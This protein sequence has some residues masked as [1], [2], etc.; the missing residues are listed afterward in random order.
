MEQCPFLEDVARIITQQ[1]AQ[2]VEEYKQSQVGD[3]FEG[4]EDGAAKVSGELAT[5][6]QQELFAAC[7]WQ[8]GTI[9]QVADEIRRLRAVEEA[10]AWRPIET[11]P[12]DG[13]PFV[14]IRADGG[15]FPAEE[16]DIL[17]IQTVLED[18]E[19]INWLENGENKCF[20]GRL[21]GEYWGIISWSAQLLGD[22]AESKHIEQSY[23]HW[24]PLPGP[25]K[26]VE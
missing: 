12:K 15:Y 19:D 5:L 7:G 16:A 25:P 3:Y 20:P 22:V 2:A 11:A 17:F 1:C 21:V 13:T 4:V 8:G 18:E 10:Q 6:F 26:G 14:G 24:M 23:T 9:H